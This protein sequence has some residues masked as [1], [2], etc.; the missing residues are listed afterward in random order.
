[1]EH[2]PCGGNRAVCFASMVGPL[3]RPLLAPEA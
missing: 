3:A 1:M 2:A